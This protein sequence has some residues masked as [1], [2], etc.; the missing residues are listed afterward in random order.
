MYGHGLE[1]ELW[2]YN[3][4][5]RDLI[6]FSEMHFPLYHRN[7]YQETMYLI[8]DDCRGNQKLTAIISDT[9]DT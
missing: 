7:V 9:V 8:A 6:I 3:Q 1:L 4:R 2:S 5:F